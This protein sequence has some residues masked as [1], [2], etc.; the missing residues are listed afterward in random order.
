MKYY[1]KVEFD[2]NSEEVIEVEA[3]NK[4]Q[5][6][7]IVDRIINERSGG[8]NYNFP[9]SYNYKEKVYTENEFN[10]INIQR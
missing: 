10:K 6:R 7:I 8:W 9:S 2:S 1:I 3:K 4:T 5:A